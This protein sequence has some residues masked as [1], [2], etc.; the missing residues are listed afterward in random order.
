MQDKTIQPSALPL[1]VDSAGQPRNLAEGSEACRHSQA[2]SALR[3]G[4]RGQPARALQS[5]R[6]RL[7]SMPHS[8]LVNRPPSRPSSVHARADAQTVPALIT[9][10]QAGARGQQLAYLGPLCPAG[11][12]WA[13]ERRRCSC[14]WRCLSHPGCWH[15]SAWWRHLRCPPGWR[16]VSS[17]QARCPGVCRCHWGSAPA[18]LGCLG[19]CRQGSGCLQFAGGASDPLLLEGLLG[20]PGLKSQPQGGAA[21]AIPAACT[22]CN[23]GGSRP[24]HERCC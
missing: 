22:S 12:T 11:R 19:T 24:L 1:E 18:G 7:A 17:L 13:A 21:E 23:I 10:M 14:L 5:A 2:A 9:N 16:P 20:L 8:S 4:C 3:L 15:R 6:D